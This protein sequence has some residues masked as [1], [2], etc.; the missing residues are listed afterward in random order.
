MLDRS[1]ATDERF[2]VQKTW[3]EL[4]IILVGKTP[5]KLTEL[6]PSVRVVNWSR[7]KQAC[8]LREDA[9]QIFFLYHWAFIN[10]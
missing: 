10:G 9:V 4:R 1:L 3:D 7:A 2:P 8:K 5:Q 6:H